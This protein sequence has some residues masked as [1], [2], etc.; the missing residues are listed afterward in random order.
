M[1]VDDGSNSQRSSPPPQSIYP[2]LEVNATVGDDG[3]PSYPPAIL[4]TY[5]QSNE[6]NPTVNISVPNISAK[7]QFQ[8]RLIDNY[9]EK[10]VINYSLGLMFTNLVR[11]DISFKHYKAYYFC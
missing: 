2:Q 7:A 9:P 4:V 3:P 11:L 6:A 10:L 1:V 5:S 8:K